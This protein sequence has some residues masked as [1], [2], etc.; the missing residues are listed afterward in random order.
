MK[1]SS[2]LIAVAAAVCGASA[3]DRP[4]MEMNMDM[5]MDMEE[6][7]TRPHKT[8]TTTGNLA[9]VTPIPHEVMHMHG[10][11]ILETD[12]TY[13]EELYWS[14][15]NTTTFFTTD[16]GNRGAFWTHVTTLSIAAFILYPI[17]IALNNIDS[18]WYLPVLSV[19]NLVL[20]TSLI[21]LSIFNSSFPETWYAKNAYRPMSYILFVVTIVHF[22]SA[23]VVRTGKWISGNGYS[24]EMG[25]ELNDYNIEGSITPL[26][27]YNDTHS[28]DEDQHRHFKKNSFDPRDSVG[29][30]TTTLFDAHGKHHDDLRSGKYRNDSNSFDL[31]EED[32]TKNLDL[33]QR[34]MES[35]G[36]DLR[37]QSK[38]S[39][40]R[41][42]YLAKLFK[43]PPLQSVALNFSR[44]FSF[45]FHCTNY[46]MLFYFFVYIP[47]GV[48]V[49]NLFG[50]GIRVFNLLAHWIKGGVFLALGLLSLA[51]YCGFGANNGWAWNKIIIFKNQVDSNSL[52]FRLMPHGGIT[53]EYFESFLI[54]FYGCTN[55]FLEHLSNPGGKWEAKD[56]QHVSIAFMFIGCGFCGILAEIKLSEWRFN[57]VLKHTSIEPSAIHSGFPGYSPNPFP[58]FTIFWTGILMSQHAQASATSTTIHVQWGNL[59]SY[60]SFFRV[61]TFILLM[62]V[63]NQ[64][65]NP[66]RPFTEL[67][68]SFCLICGGLVFMESTD[69][70]VEAIEYRG[71]TAMFTFNLSVGV[72]TILMAW[73]MAIF[74]W[75]D[76][77][78]DRMNNR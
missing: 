27:N 23:V 9:T 7:Q 68:T 51:R 24:R 39:I 36:L 46:P 48:A 31:E 13:A 44:V 18:G 77:L 49:G 62:L 59:L 20:L 76:W 40:K 32:I 26:H 57:H 54:A 35:E 11:P 43:S 73:V 74:M 67:I 10:L 12:L 64:N 70:V 78:K 72:V 14:N 22:V 50:N 34:L 15:Y 33:E 2:L 28:D 6:F 42:N 5:D 4:D 53:M 25:Y 29:S 63:P 1:P 66:S 65:L 38:S 8:M 19:Y 45:L 71:L 61:F 37:H 47:T 17:C 69:Q 41:D 75:K 56:L 55:V 60:G 52:W 21:S 30:P 16:K 58:A 3:V